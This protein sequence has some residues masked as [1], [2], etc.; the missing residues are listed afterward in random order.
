[1]GR[2]ERRASGQQLVRQNT[3]GPVVNFVVVWRAADE[4]RRQVVWGPAESHT[5]LVDAV[6]CPSKVAQLNDPTMTPVHRIL[7]RFEDKYIL[8]LDVAVYDVPLLAEMKGGHD[9]LDD[10]AHYFFLEWALPAQLL[11]QVAVRRVLHHAVDV[12][13]VVEKAV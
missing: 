8:R 7:T 4:L 9:L 11:I 6:S 10:G 1:M 2:R 12:L 3:D 5:V 13:V